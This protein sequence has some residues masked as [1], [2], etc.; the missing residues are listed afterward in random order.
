M[1]AS[2]LVFFQLSFLHGVTCALAHSPAWNFNG[3]KPL[4]ALGNQIYITN[5]HSTISLKF[6]GAQ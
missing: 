4:V 1:D 6:M 5:K 2:Y 3:Q